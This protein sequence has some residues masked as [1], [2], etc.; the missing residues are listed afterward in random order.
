MRRL[1]ILIITLTLSCFGKLFSQVAL[2][3]TKDS[4]CDTLRTLVYLS[5]PTAYDT[6]TSLSWN[7]AD[8][9]G[10][11]AADTL[12]LQISGEGV[13]PVSVVVNGSIT[14][15]L[16]NELVIYPS[17][18]ADFSYQDTTGASGYSY[19][20]RT[21]SQDPDSLAYSYEWKVRDQIAGNQPYLYYTFSE[22]GLFPVSLLIRNEEGCADSVRKELSVAESLVCPNVFTPNMDGHN[23]FFTVETD[24]TTVY[25]FIVYSRSGVKVYQSESPYISWDGR[26]LSGVEMQ[27]GVYYYVIEAKNSPVSEKTNGFVHLFR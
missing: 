11:I 12:E 25:E 24:G 4:G 20:F 17:P 3:V 1:N 13:Y 8:V 16:L 15:T 22:K 27:P 18:S 7:R 14:I 23:D 2:E 26:T 5:P 19:I 10:S 21:G 9:N 6:I